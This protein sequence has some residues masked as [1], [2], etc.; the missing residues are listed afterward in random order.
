MLAAHQYNLDIHACLKN[1]VDTI[2][3]YEDE[4]EEGEVTGLGT[5]LAYGSHV[6]PDKVSKVKS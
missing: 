2:R 1:V 6:L 3:S 5:S 4:D